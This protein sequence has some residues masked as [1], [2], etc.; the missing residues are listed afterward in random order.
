MG[1]GVAIS[2]LSVGRERER[3][4]GVTQP[5]GSPSQGGGSLASA[6]VPGLMLSRNKNCL[7]RSPI[8]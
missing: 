7:L 4:D 3:D 8:Y 6:E 1:E 2:L 5:H